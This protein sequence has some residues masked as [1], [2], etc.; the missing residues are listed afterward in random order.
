ME[1]QIVRTRHPPETY[2]ESLA[3]LIRADGLQVAQEDLR[4]RVD[5]LP[6]DD[7]LFLALDAEDLLG[8]AHLRVTHDLIHE[9]TVE[10]LSIIV[11]E[12]HRRNGVGRRLMTAAETWALQAG[13]AQLVL[14]ADVIRSGALAFFTALGY[15]QL[16]TSQEYRRDLE[17]ARRAEAPTRPQ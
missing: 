4:R 15:E 9:D 11:S 1:L 5:T 6:S 12:V 13:H 8:Y 14:R 10:L 3:R 16:N 2:L 17:V 7:R